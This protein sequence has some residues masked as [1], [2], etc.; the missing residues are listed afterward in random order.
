MPEYIHHQ[1]N[2]KTDRDAL[3]VLLISL[4]IMVFT[5]GLAYIFLLG[6]VINKAKT[7]Y[8]LPDNFNN[9]ICILF[10]KKLINNL[11]DADYKGRLNHLLQSQFSTAVI[12]GGK[13]GGSIITEAEAGLHFLQEQGL[14]QNTRVLLEQGSQNT[15]ENLKNTR[16]ILNKQSAIIISNHYHL[17][18]CAMLAESLA[19][20]YSLYAAENHFSYS[21]LN[22]G[23]CMKEAFF[24]HWF[25]SGKYWA[26]L[27]GNRRMLDKI[28]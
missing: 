16:Q 23:K 28:S 7:S 3:L 9:S 11:P 18:R 17:A 6:F 25:Y 24:L 26:I 5:A 21:W 14:K 19:I 27:T 22:I 1:L 8:K 4:V 12:M 15:L 10:G 13:T 2:P 20:R